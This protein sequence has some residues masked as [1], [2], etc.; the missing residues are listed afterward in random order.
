MSIITTFF[1][2]IRTRCMRTSSYNT[3]YNR[4]FIEL[5]ISANELFECCTTTSC[6][7]I[8][9]LRTFRLKSVRLIMTELTFTLDARNCDVILYSF[10]NACIAIVNFDVIF[11]YHTSLFTIISYCRCNVKSYRINRL[12]TPTQMHLYKVDNIAPSNPKVV[13]VSL[14]L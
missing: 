6:F 8:N 1:I 3:Y 12:P 11:I 9:Y 7:Y 10:L 13:H 5:I 14:F 4:V 2:F